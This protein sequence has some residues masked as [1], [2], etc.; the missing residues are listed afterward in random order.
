VKVKVLEGR[1]V[2]NVSPMD[3][4]YELPLDIVPSLPDDIQT[5]GVIC[6]EKR[7]DGRRRIEMRELI[8]FI[9]SR[10]KFLVMRQLCFDNSFFAI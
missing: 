7:M 9:L 1:V 6:W 8:F 4:L 3:Q 5:D 2:V 10:V